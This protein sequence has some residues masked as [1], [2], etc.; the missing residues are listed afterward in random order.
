MQ[1]FELVPTSRDWERFRQIT[2][3]VSALVHTELWRVT[4]SLREA[5]KAQ[6]IDSEM[7]VLSN[8]KS[9]G[10]VDTDLQNIIPALFLFPST[11]DQLDISGI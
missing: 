8:L 11:L 9:L 10:I 5:L 4:E 7:G 3:R 1:E 6:P 2:R